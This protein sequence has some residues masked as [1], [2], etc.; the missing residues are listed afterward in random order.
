MKS[1]IDN[2]A[3]PRLGG[4]LFD[5]GGERSTL[6]LKC[7]VNDRRAAAGCR[8]YRSRLE[9]IDRLRGKHFGI[10]M[11]MRIDR[12][13]NQEHPM[14]IDSAT[15]GFERSRRRDAGNFFAADADVGRTHA[16][17][18][19]G[20]C[21]DDREIEHRRLPSRLDVLAMRPRGNRPRCST[22]A[23]PLRRARLTSRNSFRAVN[24]VEERR[25]REAG[26]FGRAID[27]DSKP[28]SAEAAIRVGVELFV[29]VQP[30]VELLADS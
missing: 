16:V 7:V 14:S 28:K 22:T 19:D 13:W 20:V 29:T 17:W 12:S 1:V 30:R 9:I 26:D 10:E 23:N 21:A 18:R 4:P 3:M 24:R 25:Q 15:R 5:R 11:R 27:S 2:R 6:R 8:R